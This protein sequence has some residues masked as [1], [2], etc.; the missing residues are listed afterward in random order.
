MQ[1]SFWEFDHY[2]PGQS[3]AVIGS[4]IVGL[5][6]AL[7]I[8]NKYP[9]QDVVVIDEYFPP[10]GASTKNAGFAC[11]GS[12]TELLDD[13]QYMSVS[14]VEEIVS[15]RWNGMQILRDRLSG[16]GVF[17]EFNGGKEL[18]LK[19]HF[20]ENESIDL[21][22]QIMKNAIG[23]EDYFKVGA[24]HDFNTLNDQ[25]ILM[26]HE[27]QLN[28]MQMMD[29]LYQMA[30]SHD[31]KFIFGHEVID[32]ATETTTVYLGKEMKLSFEKIFICTNGF[33][34]KL[35]PQFEV[36]PARNHVLVTNEISGL[37]WN[38]VYH[39]DKG[40]Y[41]FRRIGNRI[42]LGGA[43]NLN[44]QMESSSEFKFNEEIRNELTRFLKEVIHAEAYPEFWWTGI[45]G[46]GPS[47]Y[48]ILQ[49]VNENIY[50]GVRLGGMGVAI[51][52]YLGRA[53]VDLAN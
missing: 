21:C 49:K 35:L 24:N 30:I 17:V 18:F 29:T 28:A 7:E 15:M 4:G 26:P 46:I 27:G 9:N 38:G 11:F 3:W 39:F 50:I 5:S 52:S 53:L 13:L 2:K 8:K 43:R 33:T 44:L 14:E 16:N 48:P 41:Y 1:F 6:T 47:K 40:Y 22:N 20:V 42:L 25:C 12:V 19:E 32:I 34:K 51:G 36:Y 37:E 31:I 23:I 45:L 10:Q